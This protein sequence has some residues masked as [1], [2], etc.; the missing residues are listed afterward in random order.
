MFL[1]CSSLIHTFQI[2]FSHDMSRIIQWLLKLSS[3]QMKKD[4]VKELL[5][6]TVA[7]IKSKYSNA[8]VK[9]ML[10]SGDENTK[11]EIIKAL[12]PHVVTLLS[13]TVS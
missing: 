6:F 2:V 13:H 3:P 10:K 1:F 8:L 4:I 7:M 12:Q 9:H 5:P 11:N